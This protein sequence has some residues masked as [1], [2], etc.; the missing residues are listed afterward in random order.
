MTAT[1]PS[2][3]QTPIQSLED[4]R[5]YLVVAMQIEHATIPPYLTALYSI[6][7]GTNSEAV[8]VIRSVAV[9]EML[10]LTLVCNVYNAIGGAMANTLTADGFIPTY[11]TYLP[12]GEREFE[13]GLRGFS[14]DTIATF[15]KIERMQEEAEGAPLV[16]ARQH[17]CLG[18]L[19][20]ASEGQLSFY[21]I[22]LF[23]AEV[24]RRLFELCQELGEDT[25]FCGDPTKQISQDYYY[26]GA[27]SVIVVHDLATA[28]QALRLIQEQGEGA[29]RG[30]RIYAGSA[31]GDHALAHYFRFQQLQ[32]GR[33]YQTLI[34]GRDEA[35][36]PDAPTGAQMNADELNYGAVYPIKADLRLADLPEGSEVRAKALDFQQRYSAFLGDLERAFDGAPEQLIPAVG[37]MFRLRSLA[38]E[39]V[40]TPIP[41]EEHLHAA[42][43]YT[44]T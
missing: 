44:L 18:M 4:L 43:L 3:N 1:P 13:V 14:P 34:P 36:A 12:T 27:G 37:S 29:P 38:D 35:D 16:V 31:V 2:N 20:G 24:I 40:R 11:P 8:E 19:P 39:L 33:Y 15:M 25:V 5:A 28:I 7:P 9:E 22:G 21:S 10:H 26:N 32:L 6:H 23:Y 30:H 41:G 42:P 17:S